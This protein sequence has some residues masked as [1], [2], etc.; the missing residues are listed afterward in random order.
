MNRRKHDAIIKGKHKGS[1]QVLSVDFPNLMNP[2]RKR[3][4][5]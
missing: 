3:V 4:R 2:N 5:R 1:P